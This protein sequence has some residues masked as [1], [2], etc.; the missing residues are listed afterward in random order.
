MTLRQDVVIMHTVLTNHR[1]K[2]GQGSS[3]W[4]QVRNYSSGGCARGHQG[5]GA[6]LVPGTGHSLK[7]EALL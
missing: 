6:L 4:S 2:W 7:K 1:M 5:A 3:H